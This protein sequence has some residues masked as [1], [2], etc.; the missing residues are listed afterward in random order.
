MNR[1]EAE[2]YLRTK[3]ELA[4]VLNPEE[5]QTFFLEEITPTSEARL[6]F[7]RDRVIPPLGVAALTGQ[8]VSLDN[9]AKSSPEEPKNDSEEAQAVS[10]AH[11]TAQAF[12]ENSKGL[13][14]KQRVA[15]DRKFSRSML[16]PGSDGTSVLQ[17]AEFFLTAFDVWRAQAR[18]EGGRANQM[19]D[20]IV[21]RA[22]AYVRSEWDKFDHTALSGYIKAAAGNRLSAGTSTNLLRAY[23]Q[24]PDTVAGRSEAYYQLAHSVL[25]L[26]DDY[27][28]FTFAAKLSNFDTDIL[29]PGSKVQSDIT[30]AYMTA[31]NDLP[32]MEKTRAAVMV[33]TAA[34]T[35][36]NK[37]F[38]TVHIGGSATL[39][40]ENLLRHPSLMQNTINQL[41][42]NGDKEALQRLLFIAEQVQ[43]EAEAGA[44]IRVAGERSSE[45]NVLPEWFLK[46]TSNSQ[47][48]LHLRFRD[49]IGPQASA[50]MFASKISA[51]P[52]P[53]GYRV[54]RVEHVSLPQGFMV[55]VYIPAGLLPGAER[56]IIERVIET[57]KGDHLDVEGQLEQTD[58][59][60]PSTVALSPR[61]LMLDGGQHVY[62]VYRQ[63][64]NFDSLRSHPLNE[65]LWVGLP[66]AEEQS[67]NE[68]I[69]ALVEVQDNIEDYQHRYLNCRGI[70]VN[71]ESSTQLGSRGYKYIVFREDAKKP[72]NIRVELAHRGKKYLYALDDNFNLNL[73]GQGISSARLRN[74]VHYTSLL[75]LRDYICGVVIHTEE[76]ELASSSAGPAARI[77]YLRY[78]AEGKMFTPKAVRHYI[79][80][81]KK[82]LLTK[83]EERKR[84]DP[85]QRNSTYVREIEQVN[86]QLPPLTVFVNPDDFMYEKIIANGFR[87]PPD[88]KG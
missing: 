73:D 79:E 18:T 62:Y 70:R 36:C 16:E 74:Q 46:I 49:S 7:I 52:E 25:D 80:R 4:Q 10:W 53:E 81:R 64:G 67:D 28:A 60:G 12:R 21:E 17:H 34:Q 30:V 55:D 77:D 59:G 84:V 65:L 32:T 83:S 15:E 45:A 63:S 82:D 9:E 61:E 85:Q 88:M 57:A 47:D 48:P 27:E 58:T 66:Y 86:L 2:V 50:E 33:A 56:T 68:L 44:D 3:F 72:Q 8:E 22:R 43:S 24:G 76:G 11:A 69:Q 29:T 6:A 54:A 71:F 14:G 13:S 31:V 42:V 1:E 26:S 40:K 41:V 5:R 37:N 78:L 75:L 20:V 87:L 23:F 19:I 51:R 35:I 39:S 38:S